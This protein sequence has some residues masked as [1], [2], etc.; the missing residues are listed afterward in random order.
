MDQKEPPETAQRVIDY[1]N[2]VI[3][4]PCA[5]DF[6]DQLGLGGDR[7]GPERRLFPY[8]GKR[9]DADDYLEARTLDI[10]RAH[11]LIAKELSNV[12]VDAVAEV[13]GSREFAESVAGF[14]QKR[15]LVLKEWGYF[16]KLVLENIE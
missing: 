5:E 15:A 8:K 4:S 9:L 13:F 1:F 6:V 3:M 14:G 11:P 12:D 2:A 16:S 7:Y 10:A